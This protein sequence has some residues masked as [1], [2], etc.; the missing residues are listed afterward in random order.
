MDDPLIEE[1]GYP[2]NYNT[3]RWYPKPVCMPRVADIAPE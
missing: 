3:Q 2:V 1:G